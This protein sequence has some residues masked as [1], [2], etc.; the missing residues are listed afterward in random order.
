[1]M[2]SVKKITTSGESRAKIARKCKDGSKPINEETDKSSDEGSFSDDADDRNWINVEDGSNS[3]NKVTTVSK[4]R[5]K[6]GVVQNKKK[7][8]VRVTHNALDKDLNMVKQYKTRYDGCMKEL[9]KIDMNNGSVNKDKQIYVKL[10]FQTGMFEAMKKNMVKIMIEKFQVKFVEGKDPKLETYG[11]SMAEE[12][13]SLDLKFIENDKQYTV[14]VTIFN[15]NCTM[16]VK[17]VGNTAHEIIKDQT[18]AEYF[19]KMV[20]FEVSEVIKT[21]VNVTKINEQCRK[22]AMLGMEMQNKPQNLCYGCTKDILENENFRCKYCKRKMH[23]KC[24]EN[25]FDKEDIA[26]ALTQKESFSCSDC[27]AELSPKVVEEDETPAKMIEVTRSIGHLAIIENLE[28]TTRVDIENDLELEEASE[29]C[30]TDTINTRPG[31]SSENL[32]QD[33]PVIDLTKDNHRS[34]PGDCCVWN[35]CKTCDKLKSEKVV[36]ENTYFNEIKSMENRLDIA[37]N[38]VKAACDAKASLEKEIDGHVKTLVE[39]NEEIERMKVETINLKNAQAENNIDSVKNELASV[40]LDNVELK[41][42]VEESAKN[43]SD[44]EETIEKMKTDHLRELNEL[45][46]IQTDNNDLNLKRLKKMYADLKKEKLKSEENYKRETEDLKKQKALAQTELLIACKENRNKDEER[47][48]ILRIFDGMQEVLGKMNS[49]TMNASTADRAVEYNCDKCTYKSTDNDRLKN[50]KSEQHRETTVNYYACTI[51]DT[52]CTNLNSLNDI[53]KTHMK[54]HRCGHCLFTANSKDELDEHTSRRHSKQYECDLCDFVTHIKAD[55]GEH[56]KKDHNIKKTRKS[57]NC[58]TC[59][60]VYRSETDLNKH[61][62]E[63]HTP[64]R[65]RIGSRQKFTY[66]ER[67]RN[68]FCRFWNHT[69]CLY[70]EECKFV[71]EE[72]PYCRFKDQCRTNPRCQFFHA[73][74]VSNGNSSSAGNS[75]SFLGPRPYQARRKGQFQNNRSY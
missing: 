48:T 13:Y 37:I 44:K 52:K 12:R 17:S 50:H 65:A 19:V 70:G 35:S 55:I 33:K 68:G 24:A 63:V 16:G 66:E 6:S 51:C 53:K 73:E 34:P 20:I 9:I 71:H 31:T 40:K 1:M 49:M 15:T 62:E 39:K 23:Y 67:K 38:E 28:P 64:K 47:M 8:N 11:R 21:K 30:Q 59:A 14:Q 18:V 43:L 5:R 45:K 29:E 7:P 75:S 54:K 60:N 58:E 56:E 2:V 10:E 25:M 46:S 26:Q 74:N 72:A 36:L 41:K 69:E 4:P 42:Q 22:L 3:K 57:F 27:L 61:T 32:Y